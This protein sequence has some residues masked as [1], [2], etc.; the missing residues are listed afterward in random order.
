VRVYLHTS[1]RRRSA[2]GMIRHLDL[3]LPEGSTLADLLAVAEA[4]PRGLLLV[5][6]GRT[7]ELGQ[8]LAQ[9]DEV[10][11]IPALSGG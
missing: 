10:D 5:V 2:E 6:N 1:L 9:G 11:L 8:A 3:D 4:A 7:A